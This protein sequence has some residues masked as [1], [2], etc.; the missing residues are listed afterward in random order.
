MT[1]SKPTCATKDAQEGAARTT[2]T[3]GV[4]R[5]ER[6]KLQ[7][8]E[9]NTQ[10]RQKYEKILKGGYFFFVVISAIFETNKNGFGDSHTERLGIKIQ[11]GQR[12]MAPNKI[13]RIEQTT[14]T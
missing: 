3:Y 5:H 10:S 1:V 6:A 12:C 7:W 4:T 8:T 13:T 14:K 2:E 11:G 9:S